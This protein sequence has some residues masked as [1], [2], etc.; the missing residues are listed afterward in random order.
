MLQILRLIIIIIVIT[1]ELIYI[2]DSIIIRHF[3][4]FYIGLK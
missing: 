1:R 2:Y 4:K 3:D